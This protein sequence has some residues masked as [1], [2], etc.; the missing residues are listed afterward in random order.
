MRILLRVFFLLS[1][2]ILAALADAKWVPTQ[3][4]AF[5]PL[6]GSLALPLS[7][8]RGLHE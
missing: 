6:L 1:L 3:V 2:T 5:G 4:G 8:E 7:P